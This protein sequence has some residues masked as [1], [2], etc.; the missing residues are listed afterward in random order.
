VLEP[1]GQAA[2]SSGR[3]PIGQFEFDLDTLTLTG[4]DGEVPLTMM[5]GRLLAYFAYHRGRTLSKAELLRNVW[6]SEFTGDSTLNV[7]VH[8]LRVKLA[9]A[10]GEPKLIKT[11]W[12]VG[13]RLANPAP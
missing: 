10:D 9:D 8:R 4:S 5:E 12:G 6:G 7:H 1:S 2:P 13:Y 3:I 11:N